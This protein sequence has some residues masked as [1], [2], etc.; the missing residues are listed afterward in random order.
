MAQKTSRTSLS[1]ALEENLCG[2]GSYHLTNGIG[3]NPYCHFEASETLADLGSCGQ[4]I[5]REESM[6]RFC[7][8]LGGIIAISVGTST[9]APAAKG[10]KSGE[11]RI[12]GTVVSVQQNSITIK[13]HHHKKKNGQATAATKSHVKT[14]TI[15]ANT[16]IQ[17]GG[18]NQ[19]R[20]ANLNALHKGE[21]V[22]VLAHNRQADVITIHH[23]KKKK[24]A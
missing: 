5:S 14:F 12:H 15:T 10:K 16:K 23:H 11:H 13:T 22:V 20:P 19:T 18:K 6:S 24:A 7:L 1:P 21:H 2:N 3:F 17:V 8:V 9:A 4:P